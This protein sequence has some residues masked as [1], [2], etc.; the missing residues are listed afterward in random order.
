M[1][2]SLSPQCWPTQFGAPSQTWSCTHCF[3]L[4]LF[5]PGHF[6]KSDLFFYSDRAVPTQRRKKGSRQQH[7]AHSNTLV[8]CPGW[9]HG[10][11]GLHPPSPEISACHGPGQR[12][13]GG[14]P[15]KWPNGQCLSLPM[16][17]AC[18]DVRG[19][20]PLATCRLP[21]VHCISVLP[22]APSVSSVR[23]MLPPPAFWQ[24]PRLHEPLYRRNGG[25]VLG[26]YQHHIAPHTGV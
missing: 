22:C 11:F 10:P 17:P 3:S 23:S 9:R 5:F 25:A 2:Q 6:F 14:G 26:E 24:R 1:L 18:R 16:G 12:A 13:F 4:C 15:G 8:A 20:M 19:H 21:L 7:T